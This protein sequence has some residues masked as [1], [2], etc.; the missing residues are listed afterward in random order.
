[1]FPCFSRLCDIFVAVY[2]GWRVLLRWLCC[3]GGLCRSL[4][5]YCSLLRV[6]DRLF[7]CS[8][9]RS[10]YLP[11]RVVYL[12][13]GAVY[14]THRV[15]C[16]PYRAVHLPHRVVCLPHRAV[17]LPHRVVCLPYRAVYLPHRLVCFPYRITCLPRVW[18]CPPR[19]DAV[20]SSLGVCLPCKE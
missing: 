4:L 8:L 1:M 11:H 14:L 3:E 15:V 12:P 7:V 18:G 17:Y 19:I 6:T 13:F 5:M 20:F 9:Q 2:L 16:L 10:V